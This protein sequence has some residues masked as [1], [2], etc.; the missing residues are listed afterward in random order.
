MSEQ[1]SWA[2]PLKAL[3]ADAPRPLRVLSPCCGLSGPTCAL[4]ELDLPFQSTGEYDTNVALHRVLQTLVPGGKIHVGEA[5]GDIHKVPLTSLDLTTDMVLS[6]PPC[7]PFSMMGRRMGDA[8][9]RSHVFVQVMIWIVYL[10]VN[11]RLCA[12]MIENVL[13]IATRKRGEEQSFAEWAIQELARSLPQGWEV[14]LKKADAIDCHLPQN[15]P[16][17]FIIGT[18]SGMRAQPFQRRVLRQPCPVL[19]RVDILGYLDRRRN[20]SD[21]ADLPWRQ[22]VYIIQQQEAHAERPSL[23]R[24]TEL[25]TSRWLGSCSRVAFAC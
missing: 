8:D 4:R 2:A 10:A 18:A 14:S 19:S 15:R 12:F 16:R 23:I 7:P 9:V 6:G 11:G 17:V 22:Q 13:G 21:W 20:D 24:E 5:A 25:N 3:V 1:S